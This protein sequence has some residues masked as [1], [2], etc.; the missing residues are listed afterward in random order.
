MACRKAGGHALRIGMKSTLYKKAWKYLENITPLE[1][2]CGALCGSAC[3]KGSDQDGML[4]FPGE[5]IMYIEDR[6][7]ISIVD[8]HIGLS[9]GTRIKLLVCQG[10]CDRKKRP[11]SCRIFPIIPQID[12]HGCLTFTPDLR[13]AAL[14]P[15]LYRADLYTI[16]PAF[17]DALYS[18][19]ETLA[20]D[21]RVTEYIGILT[22]QNR[23]IAADL[24]RFYR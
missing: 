7:G 19:F 6:N 5:E 8:S 9:D 14:C 12:E 4:L 21:E 23:E 3:C 24:K 20:E 13:A 22:R 18:A 1:Y 2:D 17:I 15:L 10:C 16:S 11:L